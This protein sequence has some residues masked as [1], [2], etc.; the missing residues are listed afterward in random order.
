MLDKTIPYKHILMKRPKGAAIRN[1]ELPAG[2][3]FCHYNE[4][5]E[6]EWAEIESSVAEFDGPASAA[7]YY[8]RE[9]M[10][11]AE[12]LKRRQLFIQN[13]D[14]KKIATITA[15]W[16]MTGERRDAIIHWVAVRPEYQGKGLGKALVSG[17]IK[18]MVSIEGDVDMYLHTQTWSYKAINIYLDAGFELLQ[19]ET[20]GGF[21][22]EYD[23]AIEVLGDKIKYAAT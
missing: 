18:L 14:G 11:Y 6:S 4:G 8:N 21:K 12:E 19:H 1:Y 17:G 22:N 9:F 2:Y 7:T 3:S 20:F 23:E 15:W 10:P 5:N 13:P 16:K